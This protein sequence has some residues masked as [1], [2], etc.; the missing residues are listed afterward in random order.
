VAKSSQN[1]SP[2]NPG[3]A[4]PQSPTNPASGNGGVAEGA[5][6][7]PAQSNPRPSGTQK[8]GR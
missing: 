5:G 3:P 7:G 4:N 6:K 1:S 2:R 8:P